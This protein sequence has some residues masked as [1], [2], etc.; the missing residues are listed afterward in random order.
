[1]AGIFDS[2]S[3]VSSSARKKAAAYL[4]VQI[5]AAGNTDHITHRQ[6]TANLLYVVTGLAA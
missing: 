5:P 6:Q 1:M 2:T 3:C 4:Q